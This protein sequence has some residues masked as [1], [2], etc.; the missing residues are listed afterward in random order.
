MT[1]P[2]VCQAVAVM[3]ADGEPHAQVI[4]YVTLVRALSEGSETRTGTGGKDLREYLKERLPQY[5][6][7]RVVI[8][9]PSLPLNPERKD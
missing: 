9:L 8:V 1:H 7:P 5:M 6:V 4:A 2:A 3:S